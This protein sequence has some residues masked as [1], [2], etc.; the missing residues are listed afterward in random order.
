[1]DAEL[2]LKNKLSLLNQL[3]DDRCEMYGIRNTISYL[4]DDGFTR[5][6]LLDLRFDEDDVD[7]VIANPD[8]EYDCE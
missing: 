5:E 8:A 1:M 6:E 7:Y 3:L 2:K 4:L